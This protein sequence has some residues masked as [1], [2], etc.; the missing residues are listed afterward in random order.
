VVDCCS[1]ATDRARFSFFGGRSG[2]MWQHITY[3]VPPPCSDSPGSLTI[4]DAAGM[5]VERQVR[6]Y[7]SLM[8][9]DLPSLR[10]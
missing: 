2:P 7:A 1:A 10:V 3:H 8:L 6:K 5:R 4:E 9:Q